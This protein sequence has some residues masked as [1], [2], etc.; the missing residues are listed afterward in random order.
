MAIYYL[1]H[2]GVK[3]MKWGV[4]KQRQSTRVAS[5]SSAQQKQTS[6]RTAP[7]RQT[8]PTQRRDPYDYDS[9][10]SSYQSGQSRVKS[11]ISSH[12]KQLLVGGAAV[13]VGSAFIAR[14]YLKK[15]GINSFSKFKA[16]ITAV[17]T[18]H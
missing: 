5:S 14:R 7:K 12:R 11:W 6:Q 1:S 15:H 13:A 10:Q 18:R 16:H 3:G 9:Y 17:T 8:A 4:R 2:H